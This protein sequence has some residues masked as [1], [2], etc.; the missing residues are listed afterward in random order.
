M[1]D[2]GLLQRAPTR[3]SLTRIDRPGSHYGAKVAY[4]PMP[5]DTASVFISRLL[6]AKSAGLR[7]LYPLSG[8]SQGEPGTP[9]VNGSG[10]G[11]TSLPVTGIAGGY[12]WKEGYW[13]NVV[14]ADGVHYLHNIRNS[15]TGNGTLR[16]W[17]PLRGDFPDGCLVVLDAPKIEGAIT[18]DIAWPLPTDEIVTIEFTIE[19]AA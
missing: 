19:E 17:P 3:A 6:E 11:G 4:P 9:V 15:G 5:A 16:V 10:A 8:V 2:T 13:L 1:I 7:I 18:S 14:D 12:Q